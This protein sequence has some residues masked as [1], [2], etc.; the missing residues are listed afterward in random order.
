MIY[1]HITELI[2]D[3]PLLK[4]DPKVHGLKYIDVYAKLEM[5]NPFGSL[6]D[7]IAHG[8]I[9]D[10]VEDIIAQ[11]KTVLESSS[12]NTAKALSTICASYGIPFKTVASRIKVPEVR[13][14]LQ[15]IG[16]D[17]E[18]LPGVSEC[19]DPFDPNDML[20]YTKNLV[21]SNPGKFHLT[22]Q[23]FNP[24]NPESHYRATGD[25]IVNDLGSV[26]YFIGF[27][28]TCGSTTGVGKRLREANPDTEI[29][30]V[31]ASPGHHVPGGRNAN[32]LWEVGFFVKDFYNHIVE[33][34]TA[35]GIEGVIELVQKCGLLCGPTTGLNYI[36]GMKKLHEL[37][38]ELSEDNRKTA[39]FLACDRL[40]TYMSYMKKHAPELFS[41]RTTTRTSVTDI[42]EQALQDAPTIDPEDVSAYLEKDAL[43]VD[44]RGTFAYSIG[45]IPGSINIVDELLK[46]I[47]EMG[48]AFDKTKPVIIAC[49]KGDISRRYAAFLTGQGYQAYSLTGGLSAYRQA[50][51]EMNKTT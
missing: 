32:E 50:G 18:E 45:H 31:V 22:D 12:G 28:G 38:K 44:V 46:E 42:D 48:P 26:D 49:S 37:D 30:G 8:M 39:V 7:R 24:K 47:V 15:I 13:M 10:D 17:I 19:P 21:K 43:V 3:T 1:N 5:T 33:G 25:E 27:L 16:A 41:G 20:V 36:A 14:L 6:K 2:G 29:I 11:K 34:T 4:I 51:L 23:Y 35:Q 9:K 40:E